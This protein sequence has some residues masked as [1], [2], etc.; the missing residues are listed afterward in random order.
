M[1]RLLDQYVRCRARQGVCLNESRALHPIH[2]LNR[3]A[4]F[5]SAYVIAQHEESPLIVF[6]IYTLCV[7]LLGLCIGVRLR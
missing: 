4:G 6:W 2:Y 5:E 1:D 3:T 7:L